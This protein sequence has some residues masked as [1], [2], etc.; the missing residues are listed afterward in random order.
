MLL[1][2]FGAIFPSCDSKYFSNTLLSSSAT[3]KSW[4]KA[5]S[6]ANLTG[7]TMSRTEAKTGG[8]SRARW[9][10]TRSGLVRARVRTSTRARRRESVGW[11]GGRRVEMVLKR[12]LVASKDLG[13]GERRYLPVARMKFSVMKVWG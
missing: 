7:M 1:L 5:A 11:P 12:G 13:T 3:A 8:A 2:T 4:T 6:A 9:G 10:R